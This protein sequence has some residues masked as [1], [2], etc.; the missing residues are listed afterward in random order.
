MWI[1]NVM[2]IVLIWPTHCPQV[3][4][5]GFSTTEAEQKVGPR[6]I[7]LDLTLELVSSDDSSTEW[8]SSNDAKEEQEAVTRKCA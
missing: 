5:L 1:S 2:Y 6:S 8:P 4:T 7:G 3:L